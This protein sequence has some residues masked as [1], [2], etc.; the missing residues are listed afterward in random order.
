METQ[1]VEVTFNKTS[2]IVFAAVIKSVDRGSRDVLA[3][4]A[5]GV[6]NVLQVKAARRDFPQTN[7]TV[8]TADGVLHHF[9]VNYSEQPTSLTMVTDQLADPPVDPLIFQSALT[10]T[11]IE[12]YSAGIAKDK[13]RILG[14][15]ESGNKMVITLLGI[16]IK[17]D[18]MFYHFRIVNRSNIDYDIDFLKFYIRD[19]ARIKRTASQEIEIRPLHIYGNDKEVKGNSSTDIVYALQKFTIP[20]A[21]YLQVELFE[22]NGGRHFNMNIKNRTIV[23]A[24]LLE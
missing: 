17:S 5:K 4:K 20:E 16:Y 13:R 23:N 12:N 1:N 24:R 7:L 21:K 8:I 19:K 15:S 10:E 6:E 11:D 22:Q 18:V 14:V 2:T 3:Q 9:T